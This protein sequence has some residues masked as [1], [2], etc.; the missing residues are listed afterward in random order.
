MSIE[1]SVPRGLKAQR[2]VIAPSHACREGFAR[3]LQVSYISDR[4]VGCD[5]VDELLGR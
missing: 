3:A 5:W 2:V 4:V 1:Q